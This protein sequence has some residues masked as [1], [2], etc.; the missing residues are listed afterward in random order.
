[1]LQSLENDKQ[2]KEGVSVRLCGGI[3]CAAPETSVRGKQSVLPHLSD[4]QKSQLFFF[5]LFLFMC[6]YDDL[7]KHGCI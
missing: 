4:S 1:M 3:F 7:M 6:F 2:D 5:F